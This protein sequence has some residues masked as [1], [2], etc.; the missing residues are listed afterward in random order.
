VA[1]EPAL[2][3][4]ARSTVL[5]VIGIGSPYRALLVVGALQSSV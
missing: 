2:K 4:A 1:K 5:L 3:A